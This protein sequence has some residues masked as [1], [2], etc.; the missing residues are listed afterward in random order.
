MKLSNPAD[1]DFK[2]IHNIIFDWGGVITN[3]DYQKTVD[4]FA[5]LGIE[6]F[7]YYYSQLHQNDLFIQYETGEISSET[8][9]KQLKN[10]LIAGTT[11]KQIDDA[12]CAMLLDTPMKNL[13]LIQK[14]SKNFRIF[15]LSNTNEIHANYYNTFLKETTGIDYP[16]LFEK[17]YYSHVLR[18]RKPNADIFEFVIADS[19][20]NAPETLFID[21]TEMHTDTAAKLGLNALYLKPGYT[22]HDIYNVWQELVNS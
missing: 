4:A 11:D 12:W 16:A 1:I 19:K 20:L 15:L 8:L 10:D 2:S 22:L 14:F 13:E 17:V 21:D 18:K 3:I 6:N 7:R 5:K 9:R